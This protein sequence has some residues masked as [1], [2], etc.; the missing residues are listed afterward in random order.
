MNL[1]KKE[2]KRKFKERKMLKLNK[3]KFAN[4]KISRKTQFLIHKTKIFKTK[5]NIEV[6]Y[7]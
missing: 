2:T 6:N 5:M 3:V 7:F 4:T 1:G